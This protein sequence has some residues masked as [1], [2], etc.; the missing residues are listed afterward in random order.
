MA[1]HS[2]ILAWRIPR[3]EE[4]GAIVHGVPKSRTRLSAHTYTQEDKL[5][6]PT[7]PASWWGR[8]SLFSGLCDPN[9]FHS[10]EKAFRSPES[11]V[12]TEAGGG[13][14]KE[15]GL[16]WGGFHGSMEAGRRHGLIRRWEVVPR[17]GQGAGDKATDLS[18]AHHRL[19]SFAA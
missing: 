13:V 8:Q 5:V 3:R 4:P 2:S 11:Q 16:G 12:R 14:G 19:G 7:G 18:S 6:G 9:S 17:E 10:L 15:L 1:T